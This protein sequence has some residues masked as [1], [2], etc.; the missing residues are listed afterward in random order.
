MTD[1]PSQKPIAIWL[2]VCCATVFGMVV[3]G[4]VTRLTGSGLSM[5]EWA[6]IMGALPPLNQA[7][8]NEAFRLYQQYPEFQLKNFSMNLDDFKSIFWFEYSHRLLGRAIGLMFFI[9][10]MF[11]LFTGRIQKTLT[12]KLI[13]MFILGGL[14]G[15]MGW[16]MVKSGLVNDPHVSQ[17]RLTAHLSLAIIIYAYMFWVALELLYPGPEPGTTAEGQ[18]LFRLSLIISFAIFLTMVTGAFVAGTRAGFAFN[19]FPLMDGQLIPD[20]LFYE[21]PLWRNFFENIVTVQFDHRVMATVLFVV[22]PLFWWK[23]AGRTTQPR[24]KTGLNLLLIALIIQLALGIS[25]LLLV[26]PV[27]LAAAHQG[28]ALVL[29]TAS[30]F[31]NQQLRRHG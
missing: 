11:F 16:Y 19:T 26:V 12:P 22:I 6:P 23:A 14:Q 2:L 20:G 31:V 7:E 15:L 1:T 5:V 3:L 28:G 13:A 24:I 10:F 8:W 21:K 17:Y 29:L 9:P 18:K 30:L 25:T 4:G 27:A